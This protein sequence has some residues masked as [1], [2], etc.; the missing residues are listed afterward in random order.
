[1]HIVIPLKQ[2]FYTGYLLISSKSC[3]SNHFVSDESLET[4]KEKFLQLMS[5]VLQHEEIHPTQTSGLEL[6]P[7]AYKAISFQVWVFCGKLLS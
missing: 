4:Q 6:L 2:L 5:Q 3:E 7:E 1:M